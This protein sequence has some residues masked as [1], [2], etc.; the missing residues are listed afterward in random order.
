[1]LMRVESIIFELIKGEMAYVKDLENIEAV[2]E[3]SRGAENDF[4]LT[5]RFI[6]DVHQT[7]TRS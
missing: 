6:S 5:V 2:C 4:M 1:M 7:A 3:P